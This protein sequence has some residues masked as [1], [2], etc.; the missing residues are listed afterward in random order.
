MAKIHLSA[1]DFDYPDLDDEWPKAIPPAPASALPVVNRSTKPAN[2]T[3]PA[4]PSLTQSVTTVS[5]NN[6]SK[7]E[8]VADEVPLVNRQ[9][10]VQAVQKY[11]MD[12]ELLLKTK[13]DLMDKSLDTAKQNLDQERAWERLHAEKSRRASGGDGDA[14]DAEKMRQLKIREEQLLSHLKKLEGDNRQHEEEIARLRMT[15]SQ[16]QKR[17][18]LAALQADDV[19]TQNRIR[20]KEQERKRIFDDLHRLRQLRKEKELAE[21]ATNGANKPANPSP[22]ITGLRQSLQRFF[23]RLLFTIIDNDVIMVAV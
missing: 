9:L 1:I 7:E 13:E 8:K 16:Y 20:D 19:Q 15:V 12:K 2:E 17:D 14:D 5:D 11:D 4:P 3:A 21:K 6:N 10:K 18:D 22:K 23:F